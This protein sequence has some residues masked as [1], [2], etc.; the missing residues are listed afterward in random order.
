MLIQIR[1]DKVVFRAENY[2][3]K[4]A[5]FF[6]FFFFLILCTL[7]RIWIF[8]ERSFSERTF[9]SNNDEARRR[10]TGCTLKLS[11]EG[12]KGKPWSPWG[13][14]WNF[15]Q[16]HHFSLSSFLLQYRRP[17]TR[18]GRSTRAFSPRGNDRVAPV[19]LN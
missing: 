9:Y 18:T 5:V 15:L 19:P 11:R 14:P 16:P 13:R 7:L 12:G 10:P 4:S 1:I 2:S 3:F 8:H 6:L 17:L